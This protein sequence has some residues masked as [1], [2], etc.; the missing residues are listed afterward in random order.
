MGE[1]EMRFCEDQ[2]DLRETKRKN[3]LAD[4]YQGQFAETDYRDLFGNASLKILIW[5]RIEN[6][7]RWD[8]PLF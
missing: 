7:L 6:Q 8:I 4:L 1:W 5:S 3:F 2:L